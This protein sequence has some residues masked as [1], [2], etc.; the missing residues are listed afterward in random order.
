MVFPHSW[1]AFANEEDAAKTPQRRSSGAAPDVPKAQQKRS[2]GAAKAPHKRSKD[3][4]T[5][6]PTT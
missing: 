3:A 2:K 4:A 5:A 6:L 1:Q